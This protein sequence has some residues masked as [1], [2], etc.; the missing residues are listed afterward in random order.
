MSCRSK[1]HISLI[2]IHFDSV[3]F[4]AVPLFLPLSQGHLLIVKNLCAH[5][6]G[7]VLARTLFK[8]IAKSL[9]YKLNSVGDK[10]S[11]CRTPQTFSNHSERSEPFSSIHDKVFVRS[12]FIDLYILSSM[13]LFNNL[14][15]RSFLL[16]QSKAFSIS[17]NA[18]YVPLFSVRRFLIII[19]REFIWSWQDL[20]FRKPFCSSGK[21]PIR[22][23]YFTI[24][25]FG[26][27]KYVLDTHESRL[28]PR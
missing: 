7:L 18:Q 22:L 6:W 10:Q 27:L 25:L 2:C 21:I 4:A 17:M 12:I 3:N 20:F 13:L 24:L 23:Q 9:I 19:V 1:V 5:H 28:I 11:P 14:Y 15:K 26:I 8:C 16:T